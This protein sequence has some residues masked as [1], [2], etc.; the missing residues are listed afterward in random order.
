MIRRAGVSI[1]A[2]VLI[3]S[4]AGCDNPTGPQS[5]LKAARARWVSHA[6]A[7][8]SYSVARSCFCPVEAVGP[9]TVVVRN[10]IVESRRYTTTGLDIPQQYAHL[11][12][13][14]EGLFAQVDSARANGFAALRVTYD[15]SYGYPTLI[16]VDV[17]LNAAD[18]EYMYTAKDLVVR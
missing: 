15:S 10:G 11:F 16:K 2:A 14:V 6:P 1:V 18:D 4:Q 7:G 12:P 17:I 13:A 9:A 5:D 3:F 8:Y